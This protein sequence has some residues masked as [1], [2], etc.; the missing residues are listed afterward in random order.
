MQTFSAKRFA[1]D[2]FSKR[3]PSEA[4]KFLA[5]QRSAIAGCQTRHRKHC[6]ARSVRSL[7]ARQRNMVSWRCPYSRQPQSGR[8]L[9]RWARP[10]SATNTHLQ[11][12]VST[13]GHLSPSN[14]MRATKATSDSHLTMSYS[15]PMS[16]V[17]PR[18]IAQVG[19]SH[20]SYSCPES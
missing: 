5:P 8:S 15:A 13:R 4:R 12:T 17:H 2:C 14:P 19:Q 11:P 6:L 9:V 3:C 10:G 20:M 1:C 16:R 18:V 7:G